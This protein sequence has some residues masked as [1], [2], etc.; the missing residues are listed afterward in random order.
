MDRVLRWIV[1]L[2]ALALCLTYAIVL[3]SQQAPQPAQQD[4]AAL[5][6]SVEKL[7]MEVRELRTTVDEMR[8]ET[9]RLRAE[10]AELRLQLQH[11]HAN[12]AEVGQYAAAPTAANSNPQPTQSDN[13]QPLPET[14]TSPNSK[15][16]QQ[17]LAKLDE[18]YQLLSGKVD[19]QYQ[20]KVESGS[21]YKVRLSGIVLLNLFGNSGN[22]DNLDFPA[23][24]Y[25]PFSPIT[26]SGAFG[27]TLRQSQIGLEVFGPQLL[28]ADTSGNIQFDFAGGFPASSNGASFGLARLRTG[29]FRLDWSHTSVVGGQDILFFSPESPTSIASLAEPALAYSGN[30]WG[31]LPQLRIEHRID[32]SGDSN[33]KVQAGILD[34]QTGESPATEFYRAPVAGERSRQPAYAARLSWNRT[35]FGFPLTVGVA[36]FYARQNYGFTRR[37][38]GW[39]GMADWNLPLNSWLALSGK[40]FRGRGIGGLGGGIGRSVLFDGDPNDP[41]SSLNALDS[42][43]GWSQVKVRANSKLEFNG[44]LGI[45]NPFAS[46]LRDYFVSINDVYGGLSKNRTWL[47]NFIYRPRSDLLFSTEY[48]RIRTSAIQNTIE[49]ASQVNVSMGI[50]F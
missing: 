22:S 10:T 27:G 11:S 25:P 34:S 21:K 13:T 48:R 17:H 29:T 20:T 15:N 37:A 7:A 3:L 30:L 24:A 31:W 33:F 35:S 39:A 9:A 47:A 19:D 12:V 32:L 40:F 38:D 46:D 1:R 42:I 43:G 8:G 36:G 44:A 28:G 4:Q 14:A 50:L 41:R 2:S 45:D 6:S 5:A 23:I 26:S 16:E 18:E 49:Q